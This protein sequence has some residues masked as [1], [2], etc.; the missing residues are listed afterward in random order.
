MEALFVNAGVVARWDEWTVNTPVGRL[1]LFAGK[2]EG[3][4][5]SRARWNRAGLSPSPQSS[6][7][8]ASG[9]AKRAL[10]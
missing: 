9:E 1:S 4:G 8:G 5:S 6:P 10:K 2:G 7:L 3:E